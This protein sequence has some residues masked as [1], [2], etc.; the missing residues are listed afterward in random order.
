[1]LRGQSG[2]DEAGVLCQE[3]GGGSTLTWKHPWM[4]GVEREVGGARAERP[5]E[6]K[7]RGG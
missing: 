4:D 6:R 2:A 7:R 5:R 1:V 3:R